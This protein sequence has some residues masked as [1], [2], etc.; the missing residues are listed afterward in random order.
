MID[1]IA[2]LF[3]PPVKTGGF[4]MTDVKSRVC[5]KNQVNK[6]EFVFFGDEKI[7]TT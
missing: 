6:N 7:R 5:L 4:K 1:G 2:D 3:W